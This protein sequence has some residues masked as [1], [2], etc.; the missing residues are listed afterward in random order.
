VSSSSN[1][2]SFF[3]WAVIILVCL[4]VM[5]LYACFV[6]QEWLKSQVRHERGLNHAVLGDSAAMAEKRGAHWFFVAFERT[7]ILSTSY[8]IA[9]G[10]DVDTDS[11]ASALP[12][13]DVTDWLGER[14]EIVWTMLLQLFVRFSTCLLWWQ[15]A[16]VVLIPFVIDALIARRIKQST[17]TH[18]SPHI[19]RLSHMVVS[20]L[21]IVFL[22]M[23]FAPTVL[24]P[25]LM[26]VMI[27][28]L[29]VAIWTGISQFAKRA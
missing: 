5:G 24:S 1:R 10:P 18:T 14:M 26:P 17:F 25:R 8:Q 3:G 7:G 22:L 15:Y 11:F 6:N 2:R 28:V 4:I 12:V 16:A 27:V 9:A 13:G 21:P 29:A 19:F 23:L 20:W